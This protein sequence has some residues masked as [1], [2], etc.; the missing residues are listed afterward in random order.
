MS[1][2][3]PLQSRGTEELSETFGNRPGPSQLDL[4][5]TA[6]LRPDP[7]RSGRHSAVTPPG[8]FPMLFGEIPSENGD[9]RGVMK[10]GK[11]FFR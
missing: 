10:V 6:L 11:R 1:S 7:D 2:V 8:R 3:S 4:G 9:T 5:V